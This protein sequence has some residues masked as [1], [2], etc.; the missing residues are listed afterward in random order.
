MK[1][2]KKLTKKDVT[3]LCLPV[4]FQDTMLKKCTFSSANLGRLK[5]LDELI[6]IV[7]L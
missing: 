7:G 6:T 5:I 1:Y 3:K 2:Y 4:T